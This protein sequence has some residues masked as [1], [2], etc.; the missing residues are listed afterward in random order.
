MNGCK[1]TQGP[2]KKGGPKGLNTIFKI[3]IQFSFLFQAVY[4]SYR[5]RELSFVRLR[6]RDLGYII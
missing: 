5:L 6:S 2:K 3:D 4:V 1:P